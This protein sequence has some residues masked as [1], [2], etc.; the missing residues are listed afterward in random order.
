MLS[1]P[2]PHPLFP[3]NPDEPLLQNNKIKIIQRQL[4]PPLLSHPHPPPQF[5]A[6]KSLIFVPPLI[7]DYT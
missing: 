4:L 7:F 1:H 5:V 3:E 6:A 2:H